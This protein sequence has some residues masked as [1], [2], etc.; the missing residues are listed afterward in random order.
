MSQQ[1]EETLKLRLQ[2]PIDPFASVRP[3]GSEIQVGRTIS[4]GELRHVI[5]SSVQG[6][7]IE[8]EI[9]III[10][11]KNI[12]LSR[13]GEK[14][15]DILT[16]DGVNMS[17]SLLGVFSNRLFARLQQLMACIQF[18]SLSIERLGPKS[19]YLNPL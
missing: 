11:G 5:S 8:D 17:F 15:L 19:L 18:M 6:K 3:N 14:L 1:G 12:P 16:E 9:R 4:V 7:P 10:K 2:F 13:G